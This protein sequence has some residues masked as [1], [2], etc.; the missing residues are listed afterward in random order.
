MTSILTQGGKTLR[1]NTNWGTPDLIDADGRQYA[2]PSKEYMALFADEN[3]KN[4]RVFDMR[5][6]RRVP[7][8]NRLEA[9]E[10]DVR[11]TFFFPSVLKHE[12]VAI[13]Q[14]RGTIIECYK[15]RRSNVGLVV[16][17]DW[18]WIGNAEDEPSTNIEP[19]GRLSTPR[20]PL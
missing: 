7:R 17:D 19:R 15:A 4:K 16:V 8:E 13:P 9:P 3:L 10:L 20:E 11:R 1:K 14:A 5:L 12:A 6:P 2:V 18:L